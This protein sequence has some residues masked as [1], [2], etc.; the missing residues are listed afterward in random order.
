L[1]HLFRPAPALRD[2]FAVLVGALNRPDK[3][4]AAVGALRTLLRQFWPLALLGLL[5][6]FIA[7]ISIVRGVVSAAW[8]GSAVLTLGIA[9]AWCAWLAVAAWLRDRAPESF[10]PRYAVM[11]WLGASIVTTVAM[12]C[13]AGAS[14]GWPLAVLALALVLPLC[15]ALAMVLA[16]FRFATTLLAGLHENHWGLCSGHDAGAPSATPALTDWLT[17]FFNDLAGMPTSARPL[18]FGDLWGAP[19]EPITAKAPDTPVSERAIDLRVM[20]TAVSQRMCYAIPFRDN[21]DEFFYDP[22]EWS[23]LFPASVMQ[24]LDAVS[25]VEDAGRKPVTRAGGAVLRRLPSGRHLPVVVAVR[26]SLSFPV[27]LSALPLYAIDYSVRQRG[28]VQAKR[29]WFSD[30]GIGSNLP[31]HFFDAPLPRRPTFAI[32]LKSEHPD[33]VIDPNKKAADQDGRVYLAESNSAGRSRY[34]PPPNDAKPSGL[35]DFLS[36]ILDTLYSWRDEILFPYPGYRDRI[37]QISQLPDEGGLNLNMPVAQID[38]LSDA[39]DFAGETLLTRFDPGA[40]T[41]I[42]GGW[43]NHR[44]IRLRS[45]LGLIEEVVTN[46]CV[47]DP[48]WV[49]VVD[50]AKTLRNYDQDQRQLALDMLEQLRALGAEVT[51]RGVSLIPPPAAPRPRPEMRATP[52]I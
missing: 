22:S 34:W 47:L 10:Q 44:E 14:S 36:G 31:L 21:A 17:G 26:L 40:P 39:G 15:L 41:S 38:A 13:S 46:P 27:L 12:L 48:V 8:L 7:G 30:G 35:F 45:F 33:Y 2:H 4:A 42:R 1:F 52:R 11:L 6:A 50:E 20:T 18:T 32:N 23:K 16:T 9:A 3:I 29:I 25:R 24:W 51:T 37:V 49:S 43:E 5:V 19:P 28:A